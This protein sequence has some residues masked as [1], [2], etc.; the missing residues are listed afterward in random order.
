M[1]TKAQFPDPRLTNRF[2][3]VRR[4]IAETGISALTGTRRLF[5]S[6]VG[7]GPPLGSNHRSS[8][9]IP[10]MG[11]RQTGSVAMQQ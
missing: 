7:G 8:S 5:I 10:P 6:W 2:T 9:G 11:H 3:V 1:H 4:T